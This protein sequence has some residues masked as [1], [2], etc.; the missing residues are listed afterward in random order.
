MTWNRRNLLDLADWTH[1]DFSLFTEYALSLAPRLNAVPKAPLT[2][3][4]GKTVA[5]LFFENSTRTRTSFEVAEQMTGA[6]PLNWSVSGSSVAKGETLRDTI[7]TLCSM[8]IDGIVVRHSRAGMPWYIQ[9]LVPDVPVFNAGDGA[10]SHP[11]QGLLDI[12]AAYARLGSLRG[13]TLVIIGDILYSRVARSDIL[14]FQGMGARVILSGPRTLIPRYP[15]SLGVHYEPDPRKAAAQADI[16]GL[17]RIQTE[18]Q[19]EGLFPSVA[20]YHS[21]YGAHSELMACAPRS[22]VVMHPA[23]INRGV[24]IASDVADGPAS[25]I[26]DQVR[27]GVLARMALL[28]ICLGGEAR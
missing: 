3:L 7:W 27:C 12:C 25:L 16:L 21:I 20:E 10:R 17:L 1:E 13:A 2:S 19:A 15:E 8:G 23:P 5:N 6:T 24:E 26:R 11:T 4:C 22:A 28:D 9:N 18:R 14:A